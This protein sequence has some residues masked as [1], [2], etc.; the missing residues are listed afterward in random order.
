MDELIRIVVKS[1]FDEDE[2]NLV[3]FLNRICFLIF[4]MFGDIEFLI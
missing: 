1:F 3:E 4:L 2:V